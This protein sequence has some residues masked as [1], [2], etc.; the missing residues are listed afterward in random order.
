MKNFIF[1]KNIFCHIY[2]IK[3]IF[4]NTLSKMDFTSQY[5]KMD[6][7]LFTARLLI[8]TYMLVK[9]T[10]SWNEIFYF[11]FY[12]QAALFKFKMFKTTFEV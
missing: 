1:F 6:F 3:H 7:K 12:P 2:S 10:F 9:L 11:K 4:T 5:T 8:I